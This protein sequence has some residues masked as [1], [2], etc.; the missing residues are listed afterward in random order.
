MAMPKS[1]NM[2]SIEASSTI[3]IVHLCLNNKSFQY[4]FI[5]RN[6]ILF[7]YSSGA[8]RRHCYPLHHRVALYHT[9]IIEEKDR[10]KDILYYTH[11]FIYLSMIGKIRNSVIQ[12]LYNS[13]D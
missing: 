11:I 7:F 3:V 13:P 6:V 4:A 1:C 5:Y 8:E 2:V 10:V 12:G 9:L